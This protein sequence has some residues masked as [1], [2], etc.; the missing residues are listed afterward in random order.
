LSVFWSFIKI[1]QWGLFII[2]LDLS[3]SKECFLLA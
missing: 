3:V 2:I 1:S